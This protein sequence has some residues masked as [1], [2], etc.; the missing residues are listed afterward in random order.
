M[1]WYLIITKSGILKLYYN[2]NVYVLVS[3]VLMNFFQVSQFKL[4]LCI[5]TELYNYIFYN[6]DGLLLPHANDLTVCL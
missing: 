1:Y 6:T 5:A 2:Q 3:F 4:K